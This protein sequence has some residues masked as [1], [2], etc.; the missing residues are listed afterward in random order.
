KAKGTFAHPQDAENAKVEMPFLGALDFHLPDRFRLAFDAKLPVDSEGVEAKFSVT[1]V[2]SHG[3]CWS[4]SS[5]PAEVEDD[6]AE[7][8]ALRDWSY[9]ENLRSLVP[10]LD[11]KEYSL[12]F[13]GESKAPDRTTLKITVTAKGKPEVR[14]F[15]DK[16]H[17]FL[18]SAEYR[19]VVSENLSK[20]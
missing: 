6:D 7:R 16:S 8:R 12:Q 18:V 3:K 4:K 20:K 5:F 10:L 2:F 19:S 17:G 11:D 9:V 15:F 14:L 13:S 1:Q